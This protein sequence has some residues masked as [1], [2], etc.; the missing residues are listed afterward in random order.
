MCEWIAPNSPMP[1]VAHSLYFYFSLVFLVGRSLAVSLY[2]AEIYD[3]SQRP[4]KVL[5]CIPMESWC[6]ESKRFSDEVSHDTVALTGMK[7]FYITR[8]LVLSVSIWK[9]SMRKKKI[10]NF[11]GC[12]HH[13]DL[14]A[15]PCAISEWPNNKL[16]LLKEICHF[17]LKKINSKTIKN[18]LNENWRITFL[19]FL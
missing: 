13:C 12:W 16:P 8:R 6:L 2:S 17:F 15:G 1:S 14:W 9:I 5:R 19:W 10:I 4:I 18:T 7:F 11:I 3:E